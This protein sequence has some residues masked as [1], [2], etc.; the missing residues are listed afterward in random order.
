[1]L[2]LFVVTMVFARSST[3]NHHVR[4]ACVD[5][6]LVGGMTLKEVGELH[7]PCVRS[8]SSWVNR[9]LQGVRLDSDGNRGLQH[10]DRWLTE[11][12]AY[13]LM[14]LVIDQELADL[15]RAGCRH[16]GAH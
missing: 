4:T 13:I 1:M 11:N 3:Y 12:V 2:A 10:A 6:Y 14:G 9:E 15:G 5:A 16:G 8:I 7:A